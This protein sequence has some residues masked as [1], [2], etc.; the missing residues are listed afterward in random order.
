MLRNQILHGGATYASKL[1]R[2]QVNDGCQLLGAI[3][4]LVIDL[5]MA[6]GTEVWG[7]AAFFDEPETI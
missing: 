5:M 6:T 4:P 2:D 7:R 1:N 3:V